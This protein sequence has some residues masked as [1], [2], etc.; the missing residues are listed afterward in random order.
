MADSTADSAVVAVGKVA[1]QSVTMR[2]KSHDKLSGESS[3]AAVPPHLLKPT[4]E[5]EKE[6]DEEEEEEE[7]EEEDE[8][9]E[10]KPTTKR[11][12]NSSPDSDTEL[13]EKLH[14]HNIVNG[15]ARSR[16]LIINYSG[17]YPEL[18]SDI[19]P[20]E[21][22]DI[23]EE[24]ED[25]LT[26]SEETLSSK[27]TTPKLSNASEQY[28]ATYKPPVNGVSAWQ[29]G[30]KAEISSHFTN[31]SQLQTKN[32]STAQI[33]T[34]NVTNNNAPTSNQKPEQ[35]NANGNAVAVSNNRNERMRIFV[36][37]FDYD[38]PSMSP[39]PDACDEELPFRE[40]QLIKVFGEKDADGFYWGEA[41]SRSGFVPCNMVSEVQVRG[42]PPPH[43]ISISN[44]DFEAAPMH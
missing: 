38:P 33:S 29:T 8:E 32:L 18:D 1:F 14:T 23:A 6:V 24:P 30:N 11:S 35:K 44:G 37:L 16:E 12:P 3:P 10:E 42:S 17:G 13:I 7:E 26:D 19:G 21:L 25:E 36:A 15:V 2:T 27:G 34:A 22:S 20:S 5:E 28:T 9:E 43:N 40:G 31:T 39:N 41:G 4:K